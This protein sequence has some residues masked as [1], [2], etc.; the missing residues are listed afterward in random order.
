MNAAQ[1]KDALFG[2][3]YDNTLTLLYGSERLRES[4]RRVAAAI[5]SF[6]RLYGNRENIRLFSVPGRSE[7][8]GNHTDHNRGKCLA[9]S[10]DCDILAVAAATDAPILRLRSEGFPG[11][12]VRLN[13]LAIESY[14]RFKSVALCAGMC[15]AFEQGGYRIGGFDAYT[16]SD[17][18]KGSGL[19]SSAAFEVLVGEILNC[20]YNSGTVPAAELAVFARY[21][22]NVYFGKPCGLLDQT[23][24]AVGG[25]V[26]LDFAD[27]NALIVE[28]L[29]LPLADYGYDLCV[30]NTGGS[31]SD[32]NEEYA[33]I[34]GEMKKIA[35]RYGSD[36]LRGITKETLLRDAASLR[37]SCGDRAY[38]R[39]MHFVTE[40]DRVDAAA[41]AIRRGDFPAFLAVIR[42]SGLSSSRY[43]QNVFAP[44]APH[45]QGISVALC[46][47]EDF[48]SQ[49]GED[50]A[51]RVHGGG[52]AGTM[53]A[54]VKKTLTRDYQSAMDAVFGAGACTVMSIR[55]VGAVEI[56]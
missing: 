47:A 4:R 23:A 14:P 52:F 43:L 28:K 48:L 22:E 30:T 55:P 53:Q 6:T 3:K 13:D 9:A 34:P 45:E 51:C 16:V 18:P 50:Y 17:V 49:S 15:K 36:A 26:A 19:S 54:F 35:A 46:V 41:A 20:L 29:E 37:A 5:D 10:V 44:K 39:A 25:L 56:G 31:H 24:C 21:A 27:P 33:S 32:L 8:C 40:N 1:W 11:D 12:T 7:I 42:A 38:L 2:G